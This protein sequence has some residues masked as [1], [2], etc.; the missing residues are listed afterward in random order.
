[1]IV[2]AKKKN[3]KTRSYTLGDDVLACQEALDKH[4]V[5]SV[6]SDRHDDD[7]PWQAPMYPTDVELVIE[8]L[9][10]G[11]GD[12]NVV[13]ALITYDMPNQNAIKVLV[14]DHDDYCF[15]L[16]I[17]TRKRK[18]NSPQSEG[19]KR[20]EALREC[21]RLGQDH[22]NLE[23]GFLQLLDR[24]DPTSGRYVIGT[25]DNEILEALRECARLGRRLRVRVATNGAVHLPIGTVSWSNQHQCFVLTFDVAGK[26]QCVMSLTEPDSTVCVEVT[27]IE[28]V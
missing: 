5:V 24:N 4:V 18:A 13:M 9:V 7:S 2:I 8:R 19:W 20:R 14:D 17:T 15:D 26:G 28:L 21:A 25:H 12:R 27:R 16:R 10:T 11:E 22:S 6:E 23:A 1:M 3:S